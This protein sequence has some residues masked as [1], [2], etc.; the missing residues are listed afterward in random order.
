M[1]LLAGCEGSE[2]GTAAKY[3]PEMLR[4]MVVGLNP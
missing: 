2:M 1:I 4:F 3:E